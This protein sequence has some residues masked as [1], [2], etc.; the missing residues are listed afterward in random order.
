[1]PTAAPRPPADPIAAATV[2]LA[3][4]GSDG[5]E[6]LMLKRDSNIA[7]GGMWVFP[8]GRVDPGDL[9]TEGAEDVVGAARRAAVRDAEE[10]AGLQLELDGLVPLSHWT[11]PA[12]AP[13]RYNTWF[14]LAR[15]PLGAEVLVDGREIHQHGWLRPL[16]ALGQRD[17]GQIE[18]AP[19]TWVTL[20]RLTSAGSVADAIAQ[21]RASTP[22]RF[23]T[24]IANA[25]G[26]LVALF[27]GDAGYHD[28]D[29]SRPGPRHRLVML[30][31]GWRF[32]Q[33]IDHRT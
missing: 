21:A 20:W 25:G 4:D 14:F 29:V 17:A 24:H 30:P 7:F 5:L 12:E 15:A 3:R 33:T 22:L 23:E 10:E 13:R 18:L 6:V 19:P 11:P 2:V 1:M 32:E 16:D 27:D 26:V 31:D 9:T 8:G 28:H